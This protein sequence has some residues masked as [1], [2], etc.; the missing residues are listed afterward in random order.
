M[1]QELRLENSRPNDDAFATTRDEKGNLG[2]YK[3]C[4]WNS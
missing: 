3:L 2:C 1:I 4:R